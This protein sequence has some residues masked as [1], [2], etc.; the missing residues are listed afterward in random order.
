ML[1]FSNSLLIAS[2]FDIFMTSVC[3]SKRRPAIAG[4]KRVEH[5]HIKEGSVL[6]GSEP[7]ND[8]LKTSLHQ[9]S[10]IYAIDRNLSKL[11][12]LQTKTT[13]W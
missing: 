11:Y 2:L 13:K 12:M 1:H 7:P 8:Y 9:V 3:R 10:R 4:H 6:I 5:T